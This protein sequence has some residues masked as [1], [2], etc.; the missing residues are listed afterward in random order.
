VL[1]D[2]HIPALL[3]WW[4]HKCPLKEFSL[5]KFSFIHLPSSSWMSRTSNQMRRPNS[6]WFQKMP[7][8][9]D[10]NNGRIDG[11]SVCVYT[12]GHVLPLECYT[13]IPGTFWLPIVVT[14]IVFKI[15]PT[16]PSEAIAAVL[17]SLLHCRCTLTWLERCR[18]LWHLGAL[19][20]RD[21]EGNG[22]T[23]D[24]AI[25]RSRFEMW[26]IPQSMQELGDDCSQLDL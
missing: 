5:G 20:D 8:A 9:A 26:W 3:I 16:N 18:P 13:T 7:S 19:V 22:G 1:Y 2:L 6:E 14:P 4:A 25:P 21:P 12:K 15:F 24:I 17:V 11:T 23:R 10:F